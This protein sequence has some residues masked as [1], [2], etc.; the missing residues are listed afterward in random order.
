MG[1]ELINP[2]YDR[3]E[4]GLNFMKKID[5]KEIKLWQAREE[6]IKQNGDVWKET[7]ESDLGF[8]KNSN[9][10]LWLCPYHRYTIG[11]PMEAFYAHSIQQP[12]YTITYK[13]NINHPFLRYVSTQIF[14]TPSE[15]IKWW[16][17]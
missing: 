9:G 15:F 2:F 1:I 3:D 17:S 10:V 16:S 5:K 4:V 12:V 6:K 13:K 8:C 14:T 7:V 11:A